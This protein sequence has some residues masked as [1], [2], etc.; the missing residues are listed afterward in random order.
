MPALPALLLALLTLATPDAGA[1]DAG[2]AAADGGT[3]RAGPAPTTPGARAAARAEHTQAMEQL[4]AGNVAQAAALFAAAVEHDP[5]NAGYATDYGF[6]LGRLGRRAEAEALLRGAIDKDPRRVYAWVNLAEIYADDPTRWERRDAIIAF[7]EKGLDAT[8][9]DQKRR[10]NLVLGLANFE[11]AIGRTVAARAR[12]KPLLAV[13]A[14]PPLSRAQRKRVL[15][16]LEA[17]ALDDRAHAL[18][19]WPRPEIARADA[20]QAAAAARALDTGHADDA[21][22]I[23]EPLVQRYPSWPRALV[24]RARALE[25]A[26]RVDEAARDLEIAVNLAPSD[27]VAWRT[28]GKIL[29]QHGGALEAERADDALRN[30]LTLEPGWTD[31]RELRDKLA[32]R[33]AVGHAPPAPGRATVPS[34]IARGLYQ[35]AEEWIHVGDPVGLGRE[36]LEQALADSPGFVAAAVS[37]FAISGKLP[38]AT[39]E[40]LKNDGPGLWALAA[41]VRKLGK[42]EQTSKKPGSDDVEALVGPLIDRAVALDV[43]EARFARA[44]ARAAAGDRAGAI[45]DLTAY[46]AR[47]PTP[48]HLAEARALRA[49]IEDRAGP[50][51]DSRPSPQLLARIRLLEDKPEAA[52]RALGGPC[53]GEIPADRLVALGLVNEYANQLATARVCYELAAAAGGTAGASGLVRAANLY[54]RLP[55]AELRKA[56]RRTLAAAAARIGAAEWALARIAEADG[57]RMAALAR[58]DRALA[59][60]VGNTTDGD[61]WVSDARDARKRLWDELRADADTRRDRRR[62]SALSFVIAIVAVLGLMARRRWGGRTVAGA[63][64]RRPA[65]FPDA[66]RAVGELRHDVLKH[67]A[68]VLGSLGEVDA[69]RAEILRTMTEPRPTSAVV[70]AIYERV[71]QAA[72]G[73]GSALRALAREPVFGALHRD[74]ARAEALL[75]GAGADAELAAIDERLRGPHAEAL[76][77]LLQLGPRTRLDAATLSTWIASVE[78][79]ARQAG[80]GWTAPALSLADLAVEFPVE[81]DALAAIFMNLLRN[82][83]AAI[84]GQEDGRVI[85]RV[86]RARDVTGRQEVSLALG[87]SAPTALTLEA[88]EGRESGR[89]LAIVRDLVREWRGHLVVRPD[90]LPFTKVVGACFPL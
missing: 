41:G 34:D 21:L 48:D 33:R 37:S 19:D 52:L 85:V 70:A 30:A 44:I 87:D 49:E 11:R 32:R 60:A 17:L 67:R 27:A 83:Q 15:D 77:G 51:G 46:I 45:A 90:A 69:P 39:L 89:G 36:L 16:L 78:A 1:S 2:P 73:H 64:R 74:L 63:L 50:R 5:S 38:P 71:A 35:Q 68:S 29:A 88:I 14:D 47:E 58:T 62:L 79:S 54:A 22:A 61:R 13:D 23:A 25:T 31:L 3:T 9:E 75:S 8:K 42:V 72:A 28:L 24:L 55:E 86:E 76:A 7:L 12:L 6:A 40:A 84:A 4:R 57:D 81:H 82:A 43:Q 65:L 53:T 66:A 56:D 80:G 18:D 20:A 26:G 10:F 59:L